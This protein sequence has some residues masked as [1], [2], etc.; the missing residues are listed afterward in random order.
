MISTHGLLRLKLD[1]ALYEWE[2]LN[3]AGN[4]LDRGLNIC[5]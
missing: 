1:A 2:Y 5:H 3:Q 4:V